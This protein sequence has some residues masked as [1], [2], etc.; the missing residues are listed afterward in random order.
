MSLYLVT[1]AAL[2]IFFAEKTSLYLLATR[3]PNMN[4]DVRRWRKLKSALNLA[5]VV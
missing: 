5:Y 4:L 2:Y 1:L 3:Y